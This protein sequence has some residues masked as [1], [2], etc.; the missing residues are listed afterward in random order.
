MVSIH[1][2]FKRNVA[3]F[4]SD[5]AIVVTSY[6]GHLNFLKTTL[7]KYKESGKY[8]LCAYDR[9]SMVIPDDILSIP[10]AWVFKHKTYGANKRNG[11]IW[12]EIYASGIIEA[13]SNFKYIFTVNG[14]CIWEKPENIN[15][16]IDYLGDYDMGSSSSNGTIHTCSVLFKRKTFLMLTSRLQ[17]TMKHEHRPESYSP[18]GLL[19][20]FVVKGRVKNKIPPVQAIFPKKH[21]YAGKVDH[22]SSYAQDSTWKR[23]LGFRNL[24]AEHKTS[25]QEHLEPIEKEYMDLR[26]NG[27]FLNVH[28]QSTLYKYYTTGDRRWLYK[29]WDLGEDSMFNRRNLPLDYY[30]KEPLL[31]DSKRKEYGPYSERTGFFDRWNYNSYIIKDEDYHKRWKKFIEERGYGQNG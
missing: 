19:K 22:Y 23:I 4:K 13:F 8:V 2:N 21:Q 10:D 12:N 17:A 30:G 24:G 11:W 1:K 15:K 28:E 9:H 5:M 26:N 16:M 31:D 20:D 7:S 25:C 14:D 6:D 27:A 3:P 29:Y 18:E